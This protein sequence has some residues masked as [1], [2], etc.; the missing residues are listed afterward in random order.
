MPSQSPDGAVGRREDPPLLTGAAHYTDDLA[1][2][3]VLHAVFVRAPLGAKGIGESGAIGATPAVQ[4]A[5]VDALAH[6]GVTHIDVPLTPNGS[7]A[8][9]RTPGPR[10]PAQPCWRPTSTVAGRRADSSCCI[11]KVAASSFECISSF[12]RMF[13]TWVRTVCGLM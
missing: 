1:A 9:S 3:G 8:R 5:V 10:P 11:A 7:G 4:N 2:P 6:L 13:C 12:C